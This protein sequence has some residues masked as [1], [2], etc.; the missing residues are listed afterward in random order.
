MC[1]SIAYRQKSL[2][3]GRT[4]DVEF[5]FNEKVV[6]TPRNFLFSLRNGKEYRNRF[7]LIGIAAVFNDYPLYYEAA[8]EKGLAMAGL[9]FPGNA[10]YNEPQGNENDIAVFEFIPWILGQSES[11]EEVKALL[12][13]LNLTNLPFAEGFPTSPLHFMISDKNKS[14]VVE[15]TE[16][17]LEVFDNPF[18]VMTNN[19]CSL[20][21]MFFLSFL[22]TN[23][24]FS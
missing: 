18:D 20:V 14:I 15:P 6:V 8:N 19:I 24:V 11:V 3:F 17:G 1:T 16:N 22:C 12:K 7:A 5:S 9:N 2:Y 4:L 13:N 10:V 21:F 23:G